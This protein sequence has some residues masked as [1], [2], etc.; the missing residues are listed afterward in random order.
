M[1]HASLYI[2]AALILLAIGH[3]LRADDITARLDINPNLVHKSSGASSLRESI[4]SVQQWTMNTNAESQVTELWVQ[5]V[6]LTGAQVIVYDLYGGLTNSF[7]VPFNFDLVKFIMVKT[8]ESNDNFVGIG[9]AISN[10]W[11]PWSSAATSIQKINPNTGW[12]IFSETTNGY[13]VSNLTSDLLSVTNY[14]GTTTQTFDI[15]IGGK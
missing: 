5:S 2:V 10:Q 12:Y 6:T 8:G 13:A 14:D 3:T 9:G 7:G 4:D 11:A 1:K 15:I